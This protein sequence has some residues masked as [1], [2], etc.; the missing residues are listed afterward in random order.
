MKKS[1]LN[2]TQKLYITPEISEFKTLA[3][4]IKSWSEKPA[5]RF[6]P[7]IQPTFAQI[8]DKAFS[9]IIGEPGYGKSTLIKKLAEEN[10]DESFIIDCKEL[11]KI[12]NK[13]IQERL[14]S[15]Q[16]AYF[17]G[18]DEVSPI[19][20]LWALETIQEYQQTYLGLKVTIACRSHYVNRYELEVS[21]ITEATFYEIGHFNGNQVRNFLEHYLDNEETIELILK[22][23]ITNDGIFVLRTPRYLEAFVQSIKDN[24][25]TKKEIETLGRTEIF[26]KVIYHKLNHEVQQSQNNGRQKN[27]VYITQRVLEKLAFVME[28]YQINEINKQELITYLDEVQSNVSLMFLNTGNIDEFIERTLKTVN[29]ESLSFE[30]T[31]FQEYLAAKELIRL[32][33]TEQS[34]Y[35]IILHPQLR[36][37]YLNWYDVLQY[38]LELNGNQIINSLT[39]LINSNPGHQLDERL[40]DLLLGEGIEKVDK[41]L[42][43]ELFTVLFNYYQHNGRY[44]FHK[45]DLLARLYDNTI[46]SEDFQ[47]LYPDD[48]SEIGKQQFINKLLIVSSL[49]VLKTLNS[50]S[51]P[52]WQKTIEDLLTEK[53]VS[54]HLETLYYSIERVNGYQ[55]LLDSYPKIKQNGDTQISLHLRTLANMDADGAMNIFS[56]IIQKHPFINTKEEFMDK[57]TSAINIK[58]LLDFIL[59]DKIP[60]ANIFGDNYVGPDFDNLFNTIQKN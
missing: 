49:A 7:D 54:E 11:K 44:L 36:I 8:N 10:K 18:L 12:N 6:A 1:T 21:K 30:N 55:A 5:I 42:K 51:L 59:D 4:L 53:Q 48:F 47:A 41:K 29:H 16:H 23:T 56:E 3:D 33:N 26:E 39:Q 50:K 32:S 31:E 52:D 58:K 25:L 9:F 45:N 35:D 34:L 28:I 60:H 43:A 40:I 14:Q 20:F 24:K 19:D 38:A 2:A 37:P 13:E 15:T 17:D 22:R 57:L 46:N 27:E